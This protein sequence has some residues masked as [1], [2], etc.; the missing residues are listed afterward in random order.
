MALRALIFDF[1]GLVVETE[2]IVLQLWRE[3]YARHGAEFP[4]ERW[5]RANVGTTREQST[6]Y[7]DELEE[8]ERL[9]GKRLDRDEVATRRKARRPE[10]MARLSPQPGVEQWLTEASERRLR[11]AVASSSPSGYVDGLLERLGLRHHFEYLS[12]ADV[13]GAAKPDPAVYR[14]A[15]EV[16][17]VDAA[18]AVALE[19]SPAGVRAARGAGLFTVAVPSEV[20]KVLDFTGA[21]LVVESLAAFTLDDLV[22]TLCE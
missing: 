18:D 17:G 15:L 1:D 12:C 8:L 19:D 16:L 11:L 14:H 22:K 3:E 2:S 20:T 4:V 5:V 9:T 10:L 13:A 6:G 7:L 21:D